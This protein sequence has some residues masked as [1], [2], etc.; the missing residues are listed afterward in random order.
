MNLLK[1][2]CQWITSINCLRFVSKVIDAVYVAVA[3]AVSVI[4]ILAD[5]AVDVHDV[6]EIVYVS[7]STC[8]PGLDESP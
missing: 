4:Q 2:A 6:D 5:A 7:E 3:S 1:T 8:L